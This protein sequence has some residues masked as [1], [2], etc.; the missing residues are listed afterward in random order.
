MYEYTVYS[1]YIQY[2]ITRFMYSCVYVCVSYRIGICI[3]CMSICVHTVGIVSNV[4]LD[5]EELTGWRHVHFEV[6]EACGRLFQATD[7][8]RN[9]FQR[10]DL[11][12]VKSLSSASNLRRCSESHNKAFFDEILVPETS[13]L[14]FVP[15]FYAGE[16]LLSHCVVQ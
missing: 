9:L 8:S 11:K 7:L 14:S 6:E 13:L 15:T 5:G 2:L 10:A 16:F 3:L 1:Y 4:S 12:F